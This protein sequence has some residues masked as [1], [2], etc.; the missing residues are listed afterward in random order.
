MNTNEQG[1]ETISVPKGMKIVIKSIE[2]DIAFFRAIFY[3]SLGGLGGHIGGCGLVYSTENLVRVLVFIASA[4][5][6]FVMAA[7]LRRQSDSIIR[8]V[9][10]PNSEE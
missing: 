2:K 4:V 7:Y 9:S 3:F 8:E 5:L 10:G 6:S 1:V